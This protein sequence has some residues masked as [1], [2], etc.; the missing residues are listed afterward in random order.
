M[1]EETSIF[2]DIRLARVANT[3]SLANITEEAS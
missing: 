2:E 1:Q 3:V